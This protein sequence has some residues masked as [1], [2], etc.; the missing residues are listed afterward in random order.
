MGFLYPMSRSGL[1]YYHIEVGH[2]FPDEMGGGC[3]FSLAF[4]M[5]PQPQAPHE[6]ITVPSNES[7]VS[8]TAIQVL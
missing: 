5:P 3:A 4:K 2:A 7:C 1:C 6:A 8:H